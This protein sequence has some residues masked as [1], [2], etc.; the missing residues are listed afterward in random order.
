METQNVTEKTERT[1]RELESRREDFDTKLISIRDDIAG[2][3]NNMFKLISQE[4]NEFI[5]Q[6]D[7]I[8]DPCVVE[9][10]NLE[11]RRVELDELRRRLIPVLDLLGKNI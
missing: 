9:L 10:R 8:V 3:V 2:I 1:L 6:T 4:I 5:Q 7:S 11:R